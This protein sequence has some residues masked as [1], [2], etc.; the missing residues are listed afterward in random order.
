MPP[1]TREVFLYLPMRLLNIL[2]TV[3]LFSNLDLSTGNPLTQPFF[4]STRRFKN[5][6]DT[7]EFGNRITLLKREGKIKI[8]SQ[9]VPL[10]EFITVS[11]NKQNKLLI[12]KQPGAAMAPISI[13][14]LKSFGQFIILD[15]E[16]LNSTFIQMFVFE[17]YDHSLFEPVVLTPKSKIF[18]VKI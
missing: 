8:G 12:Q 1:K 15:Q 7:I 13:I 10:G 18:R 4:F 17:N 9:I 5:T 6:A 16:Y 2:P 14:Y 3:K 11:Y